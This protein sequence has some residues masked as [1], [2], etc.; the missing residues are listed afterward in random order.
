MKKALL[1]LSVLAALTVFFYWQ[2]FSV[3][4]ETCHLTLASLPDSFQ[5]FRVLQLSDLHGR[6]FDT[7]QKDLL[8]AVADS[9]PDIICITGDLFDE[10]TDLSM[11]PGLLTG[12]TEIAPTYYVT[13]NHEWQVDK[14]SQILLQI[15]ELGVR[16]L[17]NEYVLLQRGGESLVL[18]GVHDPCGPYD[19][20]TPEEL[21]QEIRQ[22]VGESACILMLAHRNDTLDLWADLGV[23]LALAGHCHGGVVRLPFIGGLIGSGR[24][25]FPRYDAG[26]YTRG[27]TVLYVSRGLGDLRLFNRPHLP[28]LILQS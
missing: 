8:K 12:L 22:T 21:V 19:Q 18:A 26:A 6:V 20:K 2:N 1:W 16:V 10:E 25:L 3:Q 23:D 27:S 28:I 9:K 15:E 4:K 7:E 11:L 14:L 13:G 5:N 24:Q 17:K